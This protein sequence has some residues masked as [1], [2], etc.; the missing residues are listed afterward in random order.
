MNLSKPLHLTLRFLYSNLLRSQRCLPKQQCSA[1]TSRGSRPKG[2]G[3]V[4]VINLDR[5][6]DRWKDVCCELSKFLDEARR[7]LVQRAIRYSAVDAQNDADNVFDQSEIDPFYTLAD[8]LFV[9]PQPLAMPDAFDLQRPIQ[10]SRAEIAVARSHIGVWKRIAES[11]DTYAVV[12]E[13]D[14]WLE[15]KFGRL[16][17]RAWDCM[18]QSDHSSSMFD[19][20]YLSYVEAKYG[21]PKEIIS[22]NLFRPERGLWHLSGYALS[23]DG[24]KKLLA[25]LPCSGPVDLW[26]NKQFREINVVAL[27]RS[28]VHQRLDLSSTNSYSIL[29]TLSQ[30]GILDNAEGA[31]F[32]QLPPRSPVF[33][34]GPPGSGLT[35]IA[36]ALSML[37]YRCCSDLDRLPKCESEKL[38]SGRVGRIFTAYVNIGSLENHAD[39]LRQSYPDAKFILTNNSSQ[40]ST[41]QYTRILDDLEGADPLLLS[42][43][44]RHSWRQIC[45]YLRLPPPDA[46]YPDVRDRGQRTYRYVR[47]STEMESRA[48]WRSRDPSPWVVESQAE[49]SGIGV[50]ACNGLEQGANARIRFADVFAEIDPTKW[51]IR[52]DTFPGNLGL[53][54]RGNVEI[55]SDEG[56]LL[57]VADEQLGVRNFGAAAISSRSKYMHGRFEAE[58]QATNVPGLVTGFFL[59]RNSPRQEIDVEIGGNDPHRLLV[60]VFYNPGTEGAKLDYGYRGSPVSIALG[61]DASKAPHKY[62][63]EWEPNEI[64]WFVDNKLVH[65]R[66][67]WAPTPIPHLPMTLHANLWP[68]RSKEL[69]GKLALR[70]LPASATVHRISI[71]AVVAE[72]EPSK[73]ANSNDA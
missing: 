23:K 25:R 19:L 15:R 3:P 14:V 70:S 2:I 13:D 40:N 59:H 8:Q 47:G 57:W 20:L 10:M 45:E 38:L 53:F 6:E 42:K 22:T 30:I 33:V 61:F 5:K 41:A 56:L 1:F 17:A 58:L 27:Q 31:L 9:E 73:I 51:M 72:E 43:S 7:P 16:V 54:R 32:R 36:H 44:D 26:I 12:L 63:I 34:F 69:A 48:K 37:G 66:A 46:T 39:L 24:A 35:S 62:A 64:R 50:Q 11:N 18:K 52:S 28:V 4:Y 21:A 67:E 60:N 55:R 65:R 68:T 71:D 49:W 29:P